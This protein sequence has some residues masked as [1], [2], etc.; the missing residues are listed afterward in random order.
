LSNSF[1]MPPCKCEEFRSRFCPEVRSQPGGC[2]RGVHR[3]GDKDQ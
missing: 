1:A 2:K 3:R